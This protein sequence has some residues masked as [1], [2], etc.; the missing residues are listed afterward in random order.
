[1]TP[2]SHDPPVFRRLFV[3]N[4][5]L[6]HSERHLLAAVA[7][8]TRLVSL[9]RLVDNFVDWAADVYKRAHRQHLGRG[10]SIEAMSAASVYTTCRL[11]REP[12]F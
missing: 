7:E 12:R 8:M 3:W 6:S 5:R 4:N 2:A 1:M 10:H 9:L 11:Q